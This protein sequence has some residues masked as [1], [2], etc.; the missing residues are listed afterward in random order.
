MSEAP[1]IYINSILNDIRRK[2]NSPEFESGVITSILGSADIDLREAKIKTD[3]ARLEINNILGSVYVY[4]AEDWNVSLEITEIAGR[5]RDHRKKNTGEKK[6]R[7]SLRI[8]GVT[9]LGD[10]NIR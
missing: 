3:E 6:S 4:P 8:H 10:V 1:K 7:K 9:F 5:V 2:F